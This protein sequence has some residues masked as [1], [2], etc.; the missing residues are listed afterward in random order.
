ME[1][2]NNTVTDIKDLSTR[3]SSIS[4]ELNEMLA[5]FTTD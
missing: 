1:Q 3:L 4:E 5:Y 2:V